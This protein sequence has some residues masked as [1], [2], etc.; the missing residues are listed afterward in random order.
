MGAR[1][2]ISFL[3]AIG[4]YAA[5]A[6]LGYFLIMAMSSNTHDRQME[7]SMTAAFFFGPVGAIIGFIVN[8]IRLRPH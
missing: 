3:W 7:A 4:C 2:G 6:V 1:I 5:A 8:F